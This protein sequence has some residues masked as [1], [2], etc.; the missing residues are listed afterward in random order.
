MTDDFSPTGLLAR[1][2]RDL[3]LVMQMMVIGGLTVLGIHQFRPAFYESQAGF[4]FAFILERTGAM[5]EKEEY[6]AIGVAPAIMTASPV[7][8][9][10]ADQVRQR[11]IALEPIPLNRVVFLECKSYRWAIRARLPVPDFFSKAKYFTIF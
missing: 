2:L 10:V 9:T 8:E 5:T 7:P 6:Y 11:G 3:L 1:M 4:T